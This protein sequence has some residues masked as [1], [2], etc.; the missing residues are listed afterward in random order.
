MPKKFS[1]PPKLEISHKYEVSKNWKVIYKD[2]LSNFPG[3]VIFKIR[4]SQKYEVSKNWKLEIWLFAQ[5][6]QSKIWLHSSYTLATY[7]NMLA[8]IA[9]IPLNKDI[10]IIGYKNS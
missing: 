7:S 1:D 8:H 9:G 2:D 10:Y 5:C 6:T 4:N 3:N